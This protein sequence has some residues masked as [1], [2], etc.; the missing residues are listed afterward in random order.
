VCIEAARE[1]GPYELIRE[2]I[3]L[4]TR[5]MQKSLADKGELTAAS[6]AFSV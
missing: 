4:G 5:P 6:V 2:S 3:T 1:H